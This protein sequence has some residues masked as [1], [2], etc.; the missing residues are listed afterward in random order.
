MPMSEDDVLLPVLWKVAGRL[1]IA[2][3]SMEVVGLL[4][5]TVAVVERGKEATR[6]LLLTLAMAMTSTCHSAIFIV[7]D[8][9]EWK[10]G[11]ELLCRW[12]QKSAPCF[13]KSMCTVLSIRT[14]SLMIVPSFQTSYSR[15]P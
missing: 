5:A 13:C 3:L 1:Q 15:W 4:L 7:I 11:D 14:L 2:Y 9:H 8:F 12:L 6:A 10:T